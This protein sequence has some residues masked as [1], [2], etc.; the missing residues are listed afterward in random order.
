MHLTGAMPGGVQKDAIGWIR[1]ALRPRAGE[2]GVS[3]QKTAMGSAHGRPST[4]HRRL[5]DD[6][7]AVS[8]CAAAAAGAPIAAIRAA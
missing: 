5:P 3:S 7:R 6:G 4:L 2:A 1:T 8:Y